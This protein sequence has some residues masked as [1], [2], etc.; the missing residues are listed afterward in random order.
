VL[1]KFA[2]RPLV[3]K[4]DAPKIVEVFVLSYPNFCEAIVGSILTTLV[5]LY[6]NKNL[7]LPT[8]VIY[9]IAI[10]IAGLYVLLQEYKVHNLGGVNI[11]DPFDVLFSIL[12]L[13]VAFFLIYKSKPDV[14]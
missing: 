11:Y 13:L 3:L 14:K 8:N 10:S 4:S 7:R 1:V 6:F 5:M 12:G 2:L 9:A